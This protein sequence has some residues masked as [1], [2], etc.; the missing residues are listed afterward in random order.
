[1]NAPMTPAAS[2]THSDESYKFYPAK[3]VAVYSTKLPDIRRLSQD[4]DPRR[5]SVESLLSGPPGMPDEPN[6]KYSDTITSGPRTPHRARRER[7]VFGGSDNLGVDRGFRDLDIGEND[8]SNAITGGSPITKREHLDFESDDVP[9]EFGF[10][11]QAKDTNF[12]KNDYYA[13]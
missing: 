3:V 6:R 9:I 10:G 4:S 2:S 8:D 12:E 5:L 7:R 11:V 1:M 13:Q